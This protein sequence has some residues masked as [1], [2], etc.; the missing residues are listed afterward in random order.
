ML[1]RLSAEQR[2][3]HS[4]D[5]EFAPSAFMSMSPPRAINGNIASRP[6]GELVTI[7]RSIEVVALPHA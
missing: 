3:T 5:T 2:R 6:P 7:T 4:A 1:G